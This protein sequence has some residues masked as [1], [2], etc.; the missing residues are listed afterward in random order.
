LSPTDF[1]E[2][3]VNSRY[4]VLKEIRRIT[5]DPDKAED[6]Y[7]DACIS[8]MARGCRNFA[9]DGKLRNYLAA[10]AHGAI[11]SAKRLGAARAEA[12]VGDIPACTPSLEQET[13]VKID[14]H[15]VLTEEP[16]RVLLY[17]MLEG[18]LNVAEG[19]R[20]ADVPYTTMLDA[21]WRV[22]EKLRK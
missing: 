18:R 6:A 5:S 11:T 10:C 1:E 20:E 16:Y 3:L 8:A 13:Y 14:I 15:R 4:Y 9:D 7:H 22:K 17:E 12:C 19:A 21:Y 2:G